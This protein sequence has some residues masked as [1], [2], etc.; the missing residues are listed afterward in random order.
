MSTVQHTRQPAIHILSGGA[1]NDLVSQIQPRFLADTGYG[2]NGEFGAVGLMRD[3]LLDGA[4]CDLVI[5]T[6]A[7]IEK[8]V[9]SGHVIGD[10]V[11]P[12][13]I[14]RTGVACRNAD[15]APDIGNADA[16]KKALLAAPAIYFPDPLK[17]TA[18]IHFAGVLKSL[19]IDAALAER[20]RPFPNGATAMRELSRE[21]ARGAI[22]CTQVTEILYTPGVTLAGVLP[23]EF[24]LATMY[25]AAVTTQAAEPDAAKSLIDLL[26]SAETASLRNK[27][28][29][30]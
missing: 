11:R 14:V 21:T 26:T 3:R 29:F 28:G 13:G 27:G 30:E 25:V 12:V 2:I 6:Q 19:G 8:L 4:R 5:L 9:A 17:A 18:G 22:G 16:L 20:L 7:L 24:E 10:S 15:P 1:A 23:K